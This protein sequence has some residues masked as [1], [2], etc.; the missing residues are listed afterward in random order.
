[1]SRQRLDQALVERGLCE[2]REKAQRAIMAGQVLVNQQPARK[3]SEQVSSDDNIALTAPEKYVSRG[4]FKLEH[5]LQHFQLDV[6]GQTAIDLGAS[7][8][9]FTDCLLQHGAAKVHAVD[10]G[11]G[12]LAWKLRQDPRVVVMEKTNARELT[13]AHFP[14]PFAPMDLAVIDCSFISLSRL[15][16]VAVALLR[17]FGKMVA[18]IKP[19]FEAGKAEADK[20]RGVITDPA[21]HAR[22]LA[23]VESFA[24]AQ[25][26]LKW[27]GVTESPLLGPAGNKEF[28]AL[29]EKTGN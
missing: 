19:Q 7:T 9:G 2:S 17:P 26:R 14:A 15:L 16:P 12:Q 21:I 20:G 5:A 22:V 25:P 1:M 8:G 6:T 23:E 3:S 10:V 27:R 24:R 29:L 18:L 13:P 28:L 4:G 11:H